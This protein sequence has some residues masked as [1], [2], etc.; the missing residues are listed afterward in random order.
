VTD[1]PETVPD[2]LPTIV[3]WYLTPSSAEPLAAQLN[4]ATTAHLAH[5]ARVFLAIAVQMESE[6]PPEV[7]TG[8]GWQGGAIE[9]KPDTVGLAIQWGEDGSAG[10]V[11][12]LGVPPAAIHFHGAALLVDELARNNVRQVLVAQDQQRQRQ[13]SARQRIL[14][15]GRDQ[16]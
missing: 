10:G 5:A 14:G 9:V 7:K 13:A 3:V 12:N 1:E 8:G 2:H 6:N 15:G 16:N 11:L 4:G